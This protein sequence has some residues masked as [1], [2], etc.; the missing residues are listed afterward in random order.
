MRDQ[1]R[2]A[3]EGINHLDS[4]HFCNTECAEQYEAPRRRN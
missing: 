4:L 3:G 1:E 2:I